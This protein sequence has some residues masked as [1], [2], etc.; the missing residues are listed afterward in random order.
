MKLTQDGT[1]L[2][3]CWG[4]RAMNLNE[5]QEKSFQFERS[6]HEHDPPQSLLEPCLVDV[7]CICCLARPCRKA[8]SPALRDAQVSGPMEKFEPDPDYNVAS[9][10]CVPGERDSHRGT[11]DEEHH[12]RQP[13]MC[14]SRFQV[15]VRDDRMPCLRPVSSEVLR[16]PANRAAFRLAAECQFRGSTG[17]WRWASFTSAVRANVRRPRE[18]FSRKPG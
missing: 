13:I 8:F 6:G 9:T 11:E 3:D 1:R 18:A 10:C 16:Q 15:V 14:S 7:L 12:Q 2:V 17:I 5:G 4:W